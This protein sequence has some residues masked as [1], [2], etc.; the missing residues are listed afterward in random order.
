MNNR[1]VMSF[2]AD[3][4]QDGAALPRAADVLVQHQ[5]AGDSLIAVVSALPGVTNLLHEST[6]LGNYSRVHN[7]LLSMHTSIARTLV[8][9]SKDRALLIQDVTDILETY[10]W[11]GRTMINRSPTSAEAAT[12]LAIGE[13]LVARLLAGHLQN[14]GVHV[15]HA[16]EMIVTDATYQ[17]AVADVAATRQRCA[18]KLVPLLEEGYIVI[19][20]S[21]SGVT[22][23]GKLTRLAD[24]N[25]SGGLLAASSAATGLWIMTQQDGILTA[26][27]Q[28]VPDARSVPVI[29]S[30]LLTDLAH[31][32]LNV[33]TAS[34]L[35]PAIEAQV[36]VFIR[37][38]HNPTHPGTYIQ[39]A[40]QAPGDALPILIARKPIR[41][42]H[43]TGSEHDSS[44]GVRALA[45]ER[46]DA[47]V[48]QAAPGTLD[49]FL[50]VEQANVARL[51]LSQAY[52]SARID[53]ET[54][55]EGLIVLIGTDPDSAAYLA[56]HLDSPARLVSMEGQGQHPAILLPEGSIEAA[57]EKIH[58]LTLPQSK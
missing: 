47:M 57:V 41:A 6:Q 9:E 43:V 51:I 25:V 28:M 54:E 2:S 3:A 13:R 14:R 21:G 26:D 45:E 22:P 11:V 23:E 8:Q 10:N 52:P 35:A 37:S 39:P 50:R 17:A 18:D 55:R 30:D 7:K 34:A 1:I 20:G 16:G 31:H 53:A 15:V 12:I 44:D 24:A 36:P 32:G 56:R 49:F 5:R 40:P 33:P 48:G 29:A 19:I 38:I 42:I 46:I 27:P 4:V 58:N